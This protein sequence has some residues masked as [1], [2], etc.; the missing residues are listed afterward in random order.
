[1]E[2][3][4]ASKGISVSGPTPKFTCRCGVSLPPG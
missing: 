3:V 4:K 1:M 2:L